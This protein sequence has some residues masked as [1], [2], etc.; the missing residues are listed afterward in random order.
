MLSVEYAVSREDMPL[1]LYEFGA[2]QAHLLIISIDALES[3]GWDVAPSS[4]MMYHCGMEHSVLIAPSI[5]SADFGQFRE[6]VQDIA[7]AHGDWIH[8]D[9]MDNHFVPNLTFGPKVVADLK[10]HTSL[11]MDVHLMTERPES[12]FEEC[13]HAGADHVTFHIEASVHAHRALQQIRDLG[14]KAGISLVP[15]TPAS[16]ISAILPYVDIVLV[17][18]VNPGF[19]GQSYID[20]MTDKVREIRDRRDSAGHDFHIVVDGGINE[21][22]A[23]TARSAGANVLVTGSRFFKAEDKAGLV[24]QLRSLV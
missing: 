4:Q 13:A 16:A 24:S 11:P 5:L 14:L 23:T 2:L 22:T 3:T 17:M 18:T 12:L 15:S 20:S 9:V 8:V 21:D 6:A 1:V 19:G 7:D 10:R